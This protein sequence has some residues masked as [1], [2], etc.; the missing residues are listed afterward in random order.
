MLANNTIVSYAPT[1]FDFTCWDQDC[2]GSTLSLVNNIVL[3]YE[4][5][6]TFNLGGKPGGPGGFYSEKGIGKVVRANNIFYGLRSV[7]CTGTAERCVDPRFVGE[8]HF[9][10]E[11][12]LDNFDVHP[13]ASSPAR[14]AGMHLPE[15]T[16][17]YDGHPRPSSGAPTR[18]ALE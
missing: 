7:R 11:A 18:G 14:G 16:V 5:A 17:D 12:D 8:P 6:G 1:T 3:G 15:V 13:G 10:R 2:S 4:N 9:T